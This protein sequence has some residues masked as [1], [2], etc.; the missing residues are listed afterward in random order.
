MR[1]ALQDTSAGSHAGVYRQN[2]SCLDMLGLCSSD[3]LAGSH[4]GMCREGQLLIA[5][6]GSTG[7]LDSSD[8][9]SNPQPVLESLCSCWRNVSMRCP[10]TLLL[11]A[12]Q[13]KHMHKS[14]LK[15]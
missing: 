7:S 6:F 14:P 12:L 8:R 10:E 5:Y 15:P 2:S 13:L 11:R 4:A 9:W 3:H 1:Y